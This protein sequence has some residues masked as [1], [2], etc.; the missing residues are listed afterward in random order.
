[1]TQKQE[2]VKTL[3]EIIKNELKHGESGHDFWHVKRVRKI[4]LQISRQ[5]KEKADLFIVE[6]ASLLHDIADWKFYKGDSKAGGKKTEKILS[7]LSLDKNTI[8]HVCDIVDSVSF[9]GAGVVSKMKSL[10]GK[11]V[12][13]ADRL[14][15]LGAVGIARCFGFCGSTGFAI[16]NPNIKPKLH[17]TFEEYKKGS[18]AI[19]H[20]YEKLLLLKDRMNTKTGRKFAEKRHKFMEKYL[21]EFYKEW[22]GKDI[23]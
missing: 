16:Y 5:E 11:I 8:N 3:E 19:N 18:S 12:Q 14:D 7:S 13:D 20:F 21:K 2:I 4:A 17:K 15:A 22:D 23:I 6:V 1:M 9:K 10:E